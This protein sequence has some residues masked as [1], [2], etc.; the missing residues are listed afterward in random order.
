[1]GD[2]YCV[3]VDYT[4]HC[5]RCAI[6]LLMDSRR[7]VMAVTVGTTTYSYCQECSVGL[8]MVRSTVV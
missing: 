5:L 8:E 2:Y 1:M 7:T 4:P 3:L 6:K